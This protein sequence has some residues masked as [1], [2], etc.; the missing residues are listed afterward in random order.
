MAV[1]CVILLIFGIALFGCFGQIR[2]SLQQQLMSSIEG[3]AE[4]N[5]ILVE[6]E[7]GTRFRL[8]DSLA[9]ELSDG[10]E[11]IFVDKMQGFVETYQFKRMGYIAAD[12]TAK[13]TDGYRLNMSDR[14]FFQQSMQGKNFLT[15]AFEDRI[16]TSYET[17]NVFSVPVYEKNQK[18]IKGVL[19]GTCGYEMFEECLKN[20]IFEGQA[21]NYIIKIDGTIVAGSGNS[22]K[23]GI[24]KNI[25]V[26]DA[27]EDE[28]DD[29]AR[30]DDARDK[31]ISD[32]KEGKS[33]YGLDPKRKEVSL[34]YYM[35]LKIEESGEPWSLQ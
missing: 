29:D 15:D 10:D 3:V 28:R 4:Q 35:P 19:F 11:S 7:A 16:D 6:K 9:R 27:S 24:G 21:F 20:E 5:E 30:D 31:M 13:T 22:K 26:T 12:G 23:W 2:N 17:I 34:Y 1:L 8:L 33:G 32:M 14:D 25:F 18:T